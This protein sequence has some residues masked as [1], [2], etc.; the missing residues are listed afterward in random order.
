MPLRSQWNQNKIIINTTKFQ[1]ETLYFYDTKHGGNNW[2]FDIC[3]AISNT[4]TI[5]FNLTNRYT[6]PAHK[7]HH[8][9]RYVHSHTKINYIKQHWDICA[10]KQSNCFHVAQQRANKTIFIVYLYWCVCMCVYRCV[11]FLW[12]GWVTFVEIDTMN[13]ST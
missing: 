9:Y 8:K 3:F 5:Q 6:T 12:G 1:M 11:L 7:H 10:Y 13:C 2:Q 4:H